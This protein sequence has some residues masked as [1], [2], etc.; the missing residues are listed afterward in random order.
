MHRTHHCVSI[1]FKYTI[2]PLK[3]TYLF[4]KMNA[5]NGFKLANDFHQF[6]RWKGKVSGKLTLKP[7]GSKASWDIVNIKRVREVFWSILLPASYEVLSAE[8]GGCW[9]DNLSTGQTWALLGARVN[10]H[11][12]FLGCGQWYLPPWPEH[13]QITLITTAQAK[14]LLPPPSQMRGQRPIS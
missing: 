11:E 9:N 4:K 10:L 13:A 12:C 2:C 5:T 1:I 8:A 7:L 6:C 14:C 3:E